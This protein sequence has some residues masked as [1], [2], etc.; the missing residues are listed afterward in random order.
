MV[1]AEADDRL[2]TAT[3]MIDDV[4]RDTK[5][6]S[7]ARFSVAGTER[8]AYGNRVKCEAPVDYVEGIGG[9]LLDVLGVWRFEMNTVFGEVLHVDACI[10]SG[11]TSD[12][13]LGVDFMKTRG[14][15]MDFMRNE[16]RYKHAGRSVVIPFRTYKAENRQG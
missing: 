11:G 14:A 3:V 7:G 10:V 4:H 6:D 8:M 15:I 1:Y 16:V 13:L 5:L 2:P 9:F 12:F